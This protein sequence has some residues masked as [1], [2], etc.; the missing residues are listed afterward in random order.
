ML[1]SST[2]A[3]FDDSQTH[4]LWPEILTLERLSRLVVSGRRA[5]LEDVLNLLKRANQFCRMDCYDEFHE[6]WQLNNGMEVQI[7][8]DVMAHQAQILSSRV[9]V[10]NLQYDIAALDN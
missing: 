8:L 6:T 5:T 7:R 2:L 9:F 3:D 4:V 1:S 10:L